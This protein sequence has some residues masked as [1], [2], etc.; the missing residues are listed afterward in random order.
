RIVERFVSPAATT[1]HAGD[2]DRSTSH[3]G[4]C[5]AAIRYGQRFA[6]LPARD[7]DGGTALGGRRD[8][9]AA[10]YRRAGDAGPLA[11]R[12]PASWLS[13]AP[14]YHARLCRSSRARL[15]ALAAG[16]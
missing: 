15:H 4:D 1:P 2:D 12:R 14:N 16:L 5:R 10:F 7:R 11:G 6:E 3:F 13:N 8:H 9:T